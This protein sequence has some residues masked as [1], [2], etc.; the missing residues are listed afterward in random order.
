MAGGL[1]KVGYYPV[2]MFDRAGCHSQGYAANAAN[3]DSAN[4]VHNSCK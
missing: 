4:D 2:R 3:A 1:P